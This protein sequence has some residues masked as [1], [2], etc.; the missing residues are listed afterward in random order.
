[1]CGIGFLALENGRIS[2]ADKLKKT[3]KNADF[4][5]AK[6]REIKKKTIPLLLETMQCP[7]NKPQ[8]RLPGS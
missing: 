3:L 2:K 1:M 4:I 5:K 7:S 8:R 6:I